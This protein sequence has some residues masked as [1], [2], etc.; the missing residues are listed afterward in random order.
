MFWFQIKICLNINVASC[1]TTASDHRCQQRVTTDRGNCPSWY[2]AIVEQKAG[3]LLIT[4]VVFLLQVIRKGWLELHNV[5]LLNAV[6]GGREFWFVLTT[7]NIIWFKDDEVC[8]STSYHLC[9]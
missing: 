5:G 6:K 4:V 1:V 8:Q 2:D 9:L 3:Q 7:E